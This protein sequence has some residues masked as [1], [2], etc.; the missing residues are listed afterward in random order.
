MMKIRRDCFQ[1]IVILIFK[2]HKVMQQHSS[3][4]VV[5]STEMHREL[6]WESA[7]E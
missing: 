4:E 7:S 5:T 2:F 3:D 6:T 1:N